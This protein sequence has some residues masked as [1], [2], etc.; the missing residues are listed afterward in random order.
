MIFTTPQTIRQLNIYYNLLR[1]AEAAQNA[2]MWVIESQLNCGKPIKRHSGL[3][4]FGTTTVSL[5]LCGSVGQGGGW[6]ITCMKH[7]FVFAQ[8]NDEQGAT[9]NRDDK[10]LK[11]QPNSPSNASSAHNSAAGSTTLSR[12]G[13]QLEQLWQ[14]EAHWFR[15]CSRKNAEMNFW[16]MEI[17]AKA[18]SGG[19]GGGG[20]IHHMRWHRQI[21][22]EVGWANAR[23]WVAE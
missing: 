12:I 6:T 11:K 23:W 21:G 20:V 8:Q 15:K 14:A 10:R 13:N 4:S 5:T 1:V 22:G 17:S 7:D 16:M 19:G 9:R 3:I 2:I 18:T